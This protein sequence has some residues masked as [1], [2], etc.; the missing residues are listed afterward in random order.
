MPPKKG[1]ASS[2]PAVVESADDADAAF[3]ALEVVVSVAQ[4]S[5]VVA[6]KR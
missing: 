3:P 1:K 5:A 2:D 6:R 4:C